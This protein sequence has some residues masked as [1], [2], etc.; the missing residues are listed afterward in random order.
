R[1][2]SR[3]QQ[4]WV[5]NVG[6]VMEF[7]G[8]AREGRIEFLGERVLPGRAEPVKNRMTFSSVS[9]DEVRQL[10]EQS[11]DE[12]ATWTVVFDGTYRRKK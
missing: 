3:W 6:G 12:G 4:T 8:E 9:P 10:I 7:N 5:D 11:S 1:A 2:K